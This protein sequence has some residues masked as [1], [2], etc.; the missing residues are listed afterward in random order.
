MMFSFRERCPHSIGQ[1][2]IK[3]IRKHPL[4][5]IYTYR[6]ENISIMISSLR[7]LFQSIF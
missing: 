3:K 6:S 7:E 1:I 2:N 5:N 4:S